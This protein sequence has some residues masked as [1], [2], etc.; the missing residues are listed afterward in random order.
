[1]IP[2]PPLLWRLYTTPPSTWVS[3]LKKKFRPSTVQ[4]GNQLTKPLDRPYFAHRDPFIQSLIERVQAGEAINRVLTGFN[5]KVYDERVVEFP[6]FVQWLRQRAKGQDLLD[7]GSTLN[8]KLVSTIL[9]TH[10]RNV[11][12]VNPG[13]EKNQ[14]QNPVFFHLSS[15]AAAFAYPKTFSLVTC[16]STI[17]HIGF[18]NSHYGDPTPPRFTAPTDQ[19]LIESLEKIAT[20]I[21]PK[22]HVLI[23]FPFGLRE[24]I[25]HPKSVK[26]ASQAFDHTSLKKAHAAL[27]RHGIKAQ[28]TVYRATKKGWKPVQ[29]PQA[30]TRRYAQG[31]PAASAVAVIW[32]RKDLVMSSRTG[33]LAA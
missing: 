33:A 9:K 16:L 21:K 28:A 30:Y 11:W 7:I 26:M 2:I 12:F 19:P 27:K 24:G 10:V 23:S 18:D 17:E 22:G 15:L 31:T 8:H 1:M 3:N 32:G 13:L 4:V 20:L 5:G 6:F 25:V 14:L 29:N